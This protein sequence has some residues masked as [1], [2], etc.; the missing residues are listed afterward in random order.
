V[1]QSATNGHACIKADVSVD[2]YALE[3]SVAMPTTQHETPSRTGL[4][5]TEA[6][7]Q[8]ASQPASQPVCQPA[9]QPTSQP[10]SWVASWLLSSC[11]LVAFWLVLHFVAFGC[12]WLLWVASG[13]FLLMFVALVAS[14]C[15]GFVSGCFLV[16]S[17]CC[18]LLLVA[19]L[20]AFA[21]Q[22]ASL[23]ASQPASWVPRLVL[24]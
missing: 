11:F 10:A 6:A 9:S 12:F 19:F 14:G 16:A 15:M 17:G 23:P 24:R 18:L 21:S 7:S 22:P 2:V 1:I 3:S 20:V 8:Q 4:I 13:F 5:A